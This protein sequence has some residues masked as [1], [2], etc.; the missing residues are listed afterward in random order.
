M[1]AATF[2]TQLREAHETP[3]SRLGSS[4]SLYALTGGEMAADPIRAVVATEAHRA[5]DV[6]AGWDSGPYQQL[7]GELTEH[8]ADRTDVGELTGRSFPEL[9]RLGEAATPAE[10][11]GGTHARYVLAD[12]RLG[13]VVGFFV[14]DAD[15]QSASE[16]RDVRETVATD[17]D[18][19][20][21]ALQETC[22]ADDDWADAR[23]TADA[24]IEAA[25][26]DY[27]ETLEGMGVQPKNVC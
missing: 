25:Y 19:V 23:E 12:T 22:V 7:F 4:K 8:E 1:D 18:R 16:F 13:Q 14:G 21:D 9:D 26:D 20:A 24:V 6:F 5:S 2:D 3:L 17:A 10:R 15:P 27:V 11:L